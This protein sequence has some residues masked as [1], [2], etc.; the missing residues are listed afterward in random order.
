M[1][2]L[3]RSLYKFVQNISTNILRSEKHIC[4]DLK[5]EKCLSY[6]PPITL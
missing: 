5:L 4:T 6:L 3:Y 1:A 2:A